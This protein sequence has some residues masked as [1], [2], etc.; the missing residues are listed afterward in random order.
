MFRVWHWKGPQLPAAV[1]AGK[2]A[3]ASPTKPRSAFWRTGLAEARSNADPAD[4]RN[5]R[6]SITTR[7]VREKYC[8][9]SLL[10]WFQPKMTH[11][12][13]EEKRQRDKHD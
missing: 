3:E 2:K 6:G 5:F 12:I 9:T 4:V 10:Q 13:Q 8:G 1:A 11:A 7:K